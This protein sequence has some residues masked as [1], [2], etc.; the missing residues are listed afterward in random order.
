M[1][2][3]RFQRLALLEPGHLRHSMGTDLTAQIV[4]Q[5]FSAFMLA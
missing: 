5:A 4:E 2:S 3:L 1:A